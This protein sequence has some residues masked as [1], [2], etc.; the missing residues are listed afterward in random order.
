MKLRQLGLGLG[1][2][3]IALPANGEATHSVVPL[4]SKQQV[5]DLEQAW[6]AA[7]DRHDADTLR[8]ILDERFVFTI[9]ADARLYDKE[10]FIAANLRGVPDPSKSQALTG[11]TVTVDGDTA[12]SMGTDTERGT[13]NGK[14]YT[15]VARYT[16]TYIRRAGRWTA[17]AEHMDEVPAAK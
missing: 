11:R 8:S 4:D 17:L 15:E 12:V 3:W 10:A 13:R 2:A 14:P 6:T 7:E 5:M 16:V 1:L 9:G